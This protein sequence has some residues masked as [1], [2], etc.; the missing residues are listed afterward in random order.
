MQALATSFRISQIR[1]G[2]DYWKDVSVLKIS[3]FK[4]PAIEPEVS[5]YCS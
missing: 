5:G 3:I 2:M 1:G 4:L